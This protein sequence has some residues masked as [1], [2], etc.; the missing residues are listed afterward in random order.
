MTEATLWKIALDTLCEEDRSLIN[1]PVDDSI[2]LIEDVLSVVKEKER[3]CRDKRWKVTKKNGQQIILRD[4]FEK[5]AK[6]IQRFKEVGDIAVQY[7]TTAASL[8]WAAVRLVLQVSV[9]DVEIF[10]SV[11]E[12][13]ELVAQLITRCAVHEAV[14]LGSATEEIGANQSLLRRELELLYSAI[15]SYLAKA[16]AYYTRNTPKRLFSSAVNSTGGTKEGLQLILVREEEVEKVVRALHGEITTR[17]ASNLLSMQHTQQ[18]QHQ[19]LERL[20]NLLEQ[21]VLRTAETIAHFKTILE[22]NERKDI[23]QWLSSSNHREHHNRAYRDVLSGTGQ[24]IF[25]RDEYKE[26]QDSSSSSIL[27]IHG[28]PGCGKTKLLANVVQ[29]TLA[30]IEVSPSLAPLAYF[31]CSKNASNP[32]ERNATAVLRSVLKQLALRQ[33]EQI[34]ASV[35]DEFRKG[36]T[37]AETESVDLLPLTFDNSTELLLAILSDCPATI[38]ID[39]LD[40]LEDDPGG[41]LLTLKSLVRQAPNTVKIMVASRDDSTI[42]SHLK[43]CSSIAISASDNSL[44]LGVFIEATLDVAIQEHRLLRG[45]VSSDLREL[46]AATLRDGAS[47]MFLWASLHIEQLCDQ[48]KYKLES[49]VREALTSLPSTLQ[50]V[51]RQ[52]YDRIERYPSAAKRT[53][54]RTITWVLVAERPLTVS[55]LLAAVSYCQTTEIK[56][57][58]GDDLFNICAGLVVRDSDSD[59]V[60]FAHASI[61]EFLQELPKYSASHL[62]AL[63]AAQCISCLLD[64]SEAVDISD[65][66]S[67]SNN[68]HSF[69]SYSMLY[70]ARHYARVGSIEDTEFLDNLMSAFI[71]EDEGQNFQF[72][73][74]DVRS[75]LDERVTRD[76]SLIAELSAVL[77]VGKSPAFV[78][79]VYGSSTI[80]DK[81]LIANPDFDFDMTNSLGASLMYLSSRYGHVEL[82]KRLIG[83]GANTNVSGGYLGTPLQAAAYQGHDTVVRS[84]LAAGADPLQKG[85]FDS[86]IYAAIAGAHQ[87]T[88]LL[89]I[90]ECPKHEENDAERWL[91][92][93][94]FGGLY[95]VVDLLLK[96]AKREGS[97]DPL[98]YPHDALQGALFRGR[99]RVAMKLLR[100]LSNVNIAGGHFENALQAACM[101]GNYTLVAKL[102][103]MGADP[104]TT[105]RYGSP[106]NAA[107]LTGKEKVAE[108]LITKGA[109]IGPHQANAL[110][111]AAF[112]GHLS[113]VKLL[114]QHFSAAVLDTGDGYWSR[115]KPWIQYALYAAAKR[116]YCDIVKYLLDNGA[117]RFASRALEGALETHKHR[118]VHILLERIPE[119]EDYTRFEVIPCSLGSPD[120][121]IRA[122][123]ESELEPPRERQE[124]GRKSEGDASQPASRVFLKQ[125]VADA[126]A[127]L[128]RGYYEHRNTLG[129]N[130]PQGK[131]Y[132]ERLMAVRGSASEVEALISRGIN[133]DSSRYP[134]PIEIAAKVGNLD[135]VALLLDRGV[136]L[137]G[138]LQTAVYCRQPEVIQLIFRKRPDTETD[139]DSS[140]GLDKWYCQMKHQSA[141]S[142][143][144]EKGDEDIIALL[145]DHKTKSAHTGPGPSLLQVVKQRDQRQLNLILQATCESR[146]F[147]W[148]EEEQAFIS[149]A[150]K[151]AITTNDLAI[152]HKILGATN[153]LAGDRGWI[154]DAMAYEASVSNN[155]IVMEYIH[156]LANTT[157]RVRIAGEIFKARTRKPQTMW[158]ED[159]ML[160]RFMFPYSKLNGFST[161]LESAFRTL[162]QNEKYKQAME[163]LERYPDQK[164]IETD[165]GI[166]PAILQSGN[167]IF[168]YHTDDRMENLLALTRLLIEKG[169]SVT[170]MDTQ[171][172]TSLY[173]ACR[174]GWDSVVSLLLEAG[175]DVNVMH[176]YQPKIEKRGE[177]TAES[178]Q[179]I[180]SEKLNLLQLTIRNNDC[181]VDGHEKLARHKRWTNIVFKLL[182][183]GLTCQLE[184]PGL[185]NLFESACNLDVVE[186]LKKLLDPAT[187]AFQS[188]F[189]PSQYLLANSSGFHVAAMRANQNAVALLINHGADLSQKR[190]IEQ[191]RKNL[192]P[193]QATLKRGWLTANAKS[194]KDMAEMLI[195]HGAPEEDAQALLLMCIEHGNHELERARRLLQRG[196]KVLSIPSR[197]SPQALSLLLEDD[198]L[199]LVNLDT[200]GGTVAS[201]IEN[202]STYDE[203]MQRFD[204][205]QDLNVQFPSASVVFHALI[206]KN[207]T[208]PVKE[209]IALLD[210]LL[211]LTNHDISAAF[212]C[213]HCDNPINLLYLAFKNITRNRSTDI[214]EAI[215]ERGADL[216]CPSLP[217]PALVLA[218]RNFKSS[219]EETQTPA[220]R[221]LLKHGANVH[222]IRKGALGELPDSIEQTALMYAVGS[223]N[224]QVVSLLLEHG[225]DINRGFIAP[226]S[227]ALRNRVS[228]LKEHDLIDLL[229]EN[230]AKTWQHDD[231][232]EGELDPAL[233]VGSG[234]YWHLRNC[235]YSG[236]A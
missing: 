196:V 12:G 47:S 189:H 110:E 71:L 143:A 146:T 62:N 174:K 178:K 181:R 19:A 198:H 171:S 167:D 123:F 85:K 137:K 216:D 108:L 162:V 221:V 211:Q 74:E 35:Y 172:R 139:I 69:H 101:G 118:I 57:L 33:D 190:Y 78:A 133:L 164:F 4:L 229:I 112:A 128:R 228:I 7:D 25:Q 92:M 154:L 204:L 166:I 138:A 58:L 232:R 24:W 132:L 1:V 81:V 52:I 51:F 121:W 179:H 213:C 76:S 215:L 145:L 31:Y 194:Y 114:M 99:V 2:D 227:I 79:T 111:A 236:K 5:S 225:A 87:S 90:S 141:L 91:S 72:W 130:H 107:C 127:L 106:L 230:G 147:P 158:D 44:D 192:T 70:W 205:I 77:S 160:T 75:L 34:H 41:L 170:G 56:Q 125:Q 169:A 156:D 96:S 29:E 155:L 63:A 23:G 223:K 55:E 6:W 209:K 50:S 184:E 219:R 177:E 222:G 48:H 159:E 14:Y 109:V 42:A 67:T 117:E 120:E 150:V 193:V 199:A 46:I 45:D 17:T 9:S 173:H 103:D 3:L 115:E 30:S 220:V 98:E 163:L 183:K 214:F 191:E 148:T 206:D 185:I 8:P 124:L 32:A 226:L 180:E 21:P 195:N 49:D 53:A 37:E 26:W 68:V 151:F 11:G 100:S 176:T 224:L 186:D 212:P 43:D 116:G 233:G 126:E 231:K 89:I 202:N 200:L 161:A 93:A 197:I 22:S 134:A 122:D 15:L 65:Y 188:S 54:E 28:I 152:M 113:V 175:A 94:A 149:D 88:A 80:L 165:D 97:T 218:C 18:A 95:E 20:V 142:L 182:E 153:T 129:G 135:V 83:L 82:V 168:W 16:A 131:E 144:V 84:L 59:H 40:E 39:G 13:I 104:N 60:M 61:R 217:Y 27:W 64:G 38:I 207:Y 105:G 234:Y 157:E 140:A 86:A 203:I 210:T 36:R 208:L 136:D 187:W 201:C 10:S 102:L 119:I 66:D 73:V 235:L